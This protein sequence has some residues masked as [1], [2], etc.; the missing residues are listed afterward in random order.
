MR[1]PIQIDGNI[2]YLFASNNAE[3]ENKLFKMNWQGE[4]KDSIEFD[5]YV[6][7]HFTPLNING[8]LNYYIYNED[9]EEYLKFDY[10][11]FKVQKARD[12][13][14]GKRRHVLSDTDLNNDGKIDYV[15]HNSLSKEVT[16]LN[17]RLKKQNDLPNSSY[18]RFVT[19]NYYSDLEYGELSLIADKQT[20]IFRYY[21]NPAK[22][23]KYPLWF[24]I[25]LFSILFI[26]L[27][28]F[29]QNQRILRQQKMEQQLAD[30]QLQNLRNQL[31]PHFTFNVLNSVGNAIY[32]QDKEGAYDLFQRFT[33][34]IRSSLMVSDK[35][36]RTLKEELQFTQDYLEFQKIR[37]KERFNYS[38]EIDKNVETQNIRFPK[39]LVQGFAENAVKH[40]FYELDYTGQ[41]TI[42]A[43]RENGLMKVIIEDDGLGI[44]QSKKLKATSGTQKGEK[45]LEE[46]IKQINKLYQTNYSLKI[47]DKSE[48][49]SKQKGTNISILFPD[50]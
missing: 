7:K 38:F 18:L 32:K 39:M 28:L 41:I 49:K 19:S 14:L 1:E 44:N 6:S 47:E 36:F 17:H 23:Y 29:L 22:N 5:F 21:N 40:A 4:V 48:W 13:N 10:K 34:I 42:K 37:F 15:V 50:N 26:G 43:F 12:I 35:V 45:I 11:S 25:Y 16:I 27:I 2:Y 20:R 9:T 3:P 33:R 8:N 31:D 46:Q 24:S 30:L